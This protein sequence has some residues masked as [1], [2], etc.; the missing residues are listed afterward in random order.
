MK[1]Q[2]IGDMGRTIETKSGKHYRTLN[3]IP[4]PVPKDYKGLPAEKI[5]L[6][7]STLEVLSVETVTGVFF[8]DDGKNYYIDIDYTSRGWINSARIYNG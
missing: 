4:I 5:T 2:I 8:A 1:Y 7:D 6:W 3:V